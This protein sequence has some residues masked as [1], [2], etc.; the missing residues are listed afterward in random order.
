MFDA[1]RADNDLRLLLA[2]TSPTPTAHI[3]LKMRTVDC[4]CDEKCN[5]IVRDH[6]RNAPTHRA[7]P[8]KSAS[9]P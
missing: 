5:R 8:P 4:P 9:T 2:L 7:Q 6:V 3:A 1:S